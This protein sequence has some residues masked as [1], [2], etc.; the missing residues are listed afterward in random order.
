MSTDAADVMDRELSDLLAGASREIR[1]FMGLEPEQDAPSG[2]AGFWREGLLPRPSF[3][4]GLRAHHFADDRRSVQTVLVGVEWAHCV[5]GV[6]VRCP[7]PVFSFLERYLARTAGRP[8]LSLRER[9]RAL[10]H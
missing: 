9:L 4:L 1:T 2:A 3:R 6:E 10:F 7:A 5:R 8:W